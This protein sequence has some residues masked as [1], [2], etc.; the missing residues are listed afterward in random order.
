MVIE[1]LKFKVPLSEQEEYLQKDAE[2]WTATLA[3]YPGFLSKEI[4][5]NSEMPEELTLV[6][7]WETREQWKAIPLDD[8]TLTETS[9]V[10]VM[11]KSYPILESREY[12]LK[13][14]NREV[15]MQ[16]SNY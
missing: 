6:I 5:V 4:W 7:Y 1:L 11:G 15:L 9:F 13:S 3:K 16:D 10:E 8:L 2:I 12:Q 14:V